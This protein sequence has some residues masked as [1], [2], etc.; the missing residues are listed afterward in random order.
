MIV[1]YPDVMCPGNFSKTSLVELRCLLA[2]DSFIS[3]FISGRGELSN[4]D[5]GWKSG[6]F[7]DFWNVFSSLKPERFG[8]S[9]LNV[10]LFAR[11]Q[12]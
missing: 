8:L 11:F 2:T 7:H 3:L 6:I 4:I 9:Q 1:I 10:N 12:R 5:A